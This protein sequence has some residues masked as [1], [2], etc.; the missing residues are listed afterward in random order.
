MAER[1]LSHFAVYEF[2]PEYRALPEEQRRDLGDRWGKAMSVVA[3]AVHHFGAFPQA[4]EGD[5]MTWT[6]IDADD[7]AAA[8]EF[9]MRYASSVEPFRRFV[10]PTHVLWGFTGTSEYARR[11]SS[12]GMNP[13]QPRMAPYLV[14]YPFAKTSEW[15]RMSADDRRAIMGD[16]IRIGKK[17]EGIGQMLLYSTGLQDH[18]FVVV[19]ETHDLAHFSTL[20]AEL[21]GTEARGYTLR[22]TP[23]HVGIFVPPDELERLWL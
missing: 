13:M 21:R 18:E 6:A 8:A 4:V 2:L 7:P 3:D 11:R 14:V 20:V 10:R 22:D 12:S 5:F 15:Y 16:H 19:Y 17:Y 1:S 23:V 9:F